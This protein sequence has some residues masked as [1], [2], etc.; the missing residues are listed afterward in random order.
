M[1]TLNALLA[2]GAIRKHDAK[3]YGLMVKEVRASASQCFVER[4]DEREVRFAAKASK[5]RLDL[6]KRLFNT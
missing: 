3:Y 2:D 6:E 5:R 4:L 1:A